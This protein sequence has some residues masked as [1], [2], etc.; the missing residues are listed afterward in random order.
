MIFR[1]IHESRR[2]YYF[3]PANDQIDYKGLGLDVNDD[4]YIVLDK[5]MFQNREEAERWLIKKVQTTTDDRQTKILSVEGNAI[6]QVGYVTDD[7]WRIIQKFMTNPEKFKKEDVA[8][9]EVKLAN[10]LVDRDGDRF[11]EDVL[12]S[13]K[14]TL[15]GKGFL[16]GHMW[17]PPGRG[18]FYAADVETMDG[19]QWLIGKF[20]LLKKYNQELI[21]HVDAGIWN[22][23][24]IG[25]RAPKRVPIYE[26][27]D[28]D[29]VKYWEYQN[30]DKEEAEAFEGSLVWL[31]AQY[32]AEIRKQFGD[33]AEDIIGFIHTEKG[34]LPVF[35]KDI[36]A[37][38]EWTVAYINTFEDNCF[39][40]VEP[41]GKKDDE[42]RTIPK[43]ARHLPHHD[44]GNGAAGTGGKVDLPH[45]RNALAR[46]NQIKPVTDTITVEELREKA[47]RHLIAHAKKEGIGDYDI[48]EITN[49]DEAV[50]KIL[51]EYTVKV[52]KIEKLGLELPVDSDENIEKAA[53]SI[54]E[55]LTESLGFVE[56]LKKEFGDD[57]T[58]DSLKSM[59]RQAEDARKYREFLVNEIVK[60]GGLL[61]LIEKS[62]VEEE[63]KFY[64][65]L[66]IERLE[67][68]REKLI[69]R[70]D[71][72]HPN[73]GVLSDNIDLKEP[74]DDL[75]K[76]KITDYQIV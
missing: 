42:G 22:Y 50:K 40:V 12:Q 18:R 76:G 44:K 47:R 51:E 10:N 37:K 16:I 53:E 55:K 70:Y 34:T 67:K 38:R 1:F 21:D 19:V 68:E 57:V 6:K 73:K 29:K 9:Y 5:N 3:E 63:K 39:A 54:E 56:A 61:G 75:P 69:K 27:Q 17:G 66:E 71:E 28:S 65:G 7:E 13:F 49:H 43:N 11:H 8:A 25:F 24:S 4:G 45:L 20:Y 31:G 2:K 33:Q 72:T 41:T 74:G 36:G 58:I 26:S 48:L 64:S 15:I 35:G 52:L 62:A 14:K 46:M 30:T 60:F 59:K 32:G 23:V